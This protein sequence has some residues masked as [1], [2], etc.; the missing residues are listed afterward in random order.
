MVCPEKIVSQCIVHS[1]KAESQ[2]VIVYY[3][4]RTLFICMC[5]AAQLIILKTLLDNNLPESLPL[6]PLIIP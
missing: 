1:Y 3:L 6:S 2:K 5:I 4:I